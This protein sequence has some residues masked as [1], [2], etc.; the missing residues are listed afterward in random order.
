VTRSRIILTLSIWLVLSVALAATDSRPS[1]IV[2]FGI[3]A[4]GAAVVVVLLD[5]AT[6]SVAIEW[7]RP[8][9]RRRAARGVD[10]RVSS[11]RNQL[12]NARWFGSSELRAALVELVDD[13]LLAH[14]HIDRAAD[15]AAAMEVLTPT[16]RRLV[17]GP[18]RPGTAV[19]ELN[20]ILT[21]IEAL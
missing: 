8:R 21:D 15:P 5:V 6:E 10:Q 1:V 12:Y 19:R 3:V 16:L 2:L 4:V 11:L 17:A 14:R 20:R 18:R 9:A 13:R 7:L